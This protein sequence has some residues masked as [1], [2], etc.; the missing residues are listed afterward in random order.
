MKCRFAGRL[1]FVLVLSILVARAEAQPLNGVWRGKISI[2]QGLGNRGYQ[3]ELK[4]IRV[5]DSLRG[6]AYYYQSADRYARTLVRG[7]VDPADG[8]VRWWD[9]TLLEGTMPAPSGGPVSVTAD[10]NCPGEGIMKL[11]GETGLQNQSSAKKG[12]VHLDKK[13]APLFADGWDELIA[14][15]PVEGADLGRIRELEIAMAGRPAPAPV[16]Q[17]RPAAPVRTKSPEKTSPVKK[18]ESSPVPDT[19]AVTAIPGPKPPA[20]IEEKFTRRSRKLVTEIP[21]QG[22]TLEINFYDHAEIDGD[23]ISL[24]MGNRLL[25]EHI[26][27]KA[28]PYTLK[29]AVKDLQ[30]QTELTMVAENLGSIPPNTSLMIAYI[31]GQ[32][33]EARLE[34][35]ENSSAMIRFVKPAAA[36]R[37]P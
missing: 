1:C 31:D 8:T 7:Y 10:F 13:D 37:R 5:E 32:R 15:G 2:P 33:Y 16:A 27:L 24:F 12:V 20:T 11:D 28:S 30:E 4:L 23:S 35:T 25:Q 18:T 29:F 17:S 26:L 9:E 19:Q 36:K 6:I 34:S 22:D 3:V 21:L 14:D